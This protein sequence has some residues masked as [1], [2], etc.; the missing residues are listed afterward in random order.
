MN[1][2]E[3]RRAILPE[4]L[5]VPFVVVSSFV[6]REMALEAVDLKIDS[7]VD[8][9]IDEEG[10]AALVKK[11]S[12]ARVEAIREAQALEAI[13]LDEARSILEEL[14]PVLLF[15]DGDRSNLSNL[16]LVYRY[17]HTIKGSSGVLKTDVVTRYVHRLEDIISSVKD[18]KTK[19]TDQ[20]FEVVLKGFDR[21]RELIGKVKSREIERV[22][23]QK[24][25]P[26]LEINNSG[27]SSGQLGHHAPTEVTD[28]GKAQGG[29]KAKD[30]ITVPLVMLDEL[31]SYS[32]E[33]TVIRNMVNKLVKSLERRYAGNKDVQSLGELLDEMHKIN[34]TIQLRI[35]ELR[36]VPMATVLRPIP[37]I[38]RDLGKELQ[39][40]I[41]LE[42]E[43]ES[44][45]VDNALAN[46][47][48]N[49]IVHLVR[50][51][52][53]HG[54]EGTNERA[55]AGKSGGGTIRITCQE[56][57]EHVIITVRDDGRGLDCQKIRGKALEKG[58]YTKEQ[59]AKMSDE[60]VFEIIFDAGFSTAAKVT[61]VSGRGVGMD[62]V[63]SSVQ[64]AG[65]Q[66]TIES[67]A[68]HGTAF[69]LKLPIP[70]S[71]LII[72][73]LL[74]ESA[75]KSFAVPQDAIIKVVR[76]ESDHYQ[77]MIQEVASGKVLRIGG[78][79]FPLINLGEVLS[80]KLDD[81]GDNAKVGPSVVEILILKTD[82]INY[83]LEVDAIFDS[84]EIVVKSI[85]NFFNPRGAFGGA[86]FMGDGS[87]G[88]I[89]DTKGIPHLAGIQQEMDLP[90]Q[91]AAAEMESDQ[92]GQVLRNY[93]LFSLN[94]KAVYGVP[95]EQVFR[96]EEIDASIVQ[97]SGAERVVVYRDSVMPMYSLAQLLKLKKN[98]DKSADSQS[99]RD[100]I[101]TI[102][103]LGH[104]GYFGLEV[105]T[106]VDIAA[107]ASDVSQDIRDRRGIV[108]NAT[109]R[110]CN[111][112]VLDLPQ[113]LGGKLTA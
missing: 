13:F 66:I 95:L 50:N 49:S 60:S 5:A 107:T 61:D 24:L 25:L 51:S 44:L 94:T 43:G 88:L 2:F 3:F 12:T 79:I 103:A 69:I 100:R 46:V 91:T 20:V 78:D 85:Q 63:R 80:L 48:S 65:G 38:V 99:H 62:M 89:L 81:L 58:L 23:L 32:G 93:L 83:A 111:V 55:A 29:Q 77:D 74:V 14:E 101:P 76:I 27:Q 15:L 104:R 54:I 110:D 9:P 72:N 109:I 21:V 26:E 112:T 6:S 97:R 34:G 67:R 86:T 70:K 90:T 87:V 10:I 68:G 11:F 4:A 42:I 22:D 8:K 7:F 18:G 84:E 39:K 30:S 71:V 47:C 59:L 105:D 64:S 102:V 82:K 98:S 1:G 75:G 56:A 41:K 45:R 53:D 92:V 40:A 113:I 36:K 73:S 28:P 108:G 57:N 37:R 31:S 19:F 52:A 106:V 17:A 16:N 33:I 35:T 96:L